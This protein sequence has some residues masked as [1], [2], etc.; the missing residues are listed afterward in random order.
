MTTSTR[1]LMPTM[2][3]CMFLLTLVFVNG[4]DRRERSTSKTAGSKMASTFNNINRIEYKH[5]GILQLVGVPSKAIAYAGD[6][7]AARAEVKFD[8]N[9]QPGS[10]KTLDVEE[11]HFDMAGNVVYQGKILFVAQFAGYIVQTETPIL[12]NRSLRAFTSW[13]ASQ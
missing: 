8:G 2:T 3:A 10:L 6:A 7:I 5:D 9:L 13:P 11:T 1:G 12:G 4:C